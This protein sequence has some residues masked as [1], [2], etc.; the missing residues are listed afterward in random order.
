MQRVQAQIGEQDPPEDKDAEAHSDN[1]KRHN[2][3]N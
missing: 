3:S 2:H 1:H